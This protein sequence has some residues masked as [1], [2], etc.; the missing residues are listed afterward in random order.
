MAAQPAGSTA[1][2]FPPDPAPNQLLE[3]LADVL[4]RAPADWAPLVQAW[5]ASADGQRLLQ[6]VAQRQADGARIY[7]AAVL[8]ALDLSPRAKVRVVVLGQDPYHGAGQAEGLAFSVPPG[9]KPPPSLRNILGEISRSLGVPHPPNGHLGG[10]ARQGVLLLNTVLT[11]EDAVPAAHAGR[12]WESFTDAVIRATAADPV[13]KVYLL[14]GAHAQAK[15][16][17]IDAAGGGRHRVLQA[18]HP[19]PLS[20]RRPPVPFIG[21][22]HFTQVRDFLAAAGTPPIDWS[23]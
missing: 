21:C 4:S 17:L 23:A 6:F 1:A 14:W 7:P 12:G 3:P 13:A 20:A 10:W 11:V 22:G 2:L 19:S 16:A 15:A 8:Q 9:V 18:N 5:Q